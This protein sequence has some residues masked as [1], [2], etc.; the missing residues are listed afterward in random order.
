M[1]EGEAAGQAKEPTAKR[2]EE[3]KA[4]GQLKKQL[5][6]LEAREFALIEERVMTS[7]AALATAKARVESPEVATDAA[8]LQQALADL[9]AA[10][11]DNDALYARWAEL[12]EKTE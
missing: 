10:Q 1:A 11:R 2:A 3:P 8:A 9:E 7:D 4:T 5:S 6:Y 12:S